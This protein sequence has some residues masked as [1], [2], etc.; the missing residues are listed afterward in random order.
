MGYA[1]EFQ[2]HDRFPG[3]QPFGNFGANVGESI[4]LE[5]GG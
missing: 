4:V 2:G 5:G 1:G 3:T